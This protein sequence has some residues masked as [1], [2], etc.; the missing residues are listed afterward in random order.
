[1]PVPSGQISAAILATGKLNDRKTRK[2]ALLNRTIA[3]GTFIA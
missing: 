1:M 3:E 2:R